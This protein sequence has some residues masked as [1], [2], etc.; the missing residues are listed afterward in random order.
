VIDFE[1]IKKT[2]VNI[3]K[4]NMNIQNGESVLVLNDVPNPEE[5]N[6]SYSKV[7]D[8]VERSLMARKIYDLLK[9]EFKEH[10]IEYIVYRSVGQHGTEPPNEIAEKLIDYDV[11]L[12]ITTFSITHTKAKENATQKGTRIASMP[13]LKVDMLAAD[14]AI[15]ADYNA[16][17]G[18]TIKIAEKLTE[19]KIARIITEYGTDIS[20]SI[21][22]RNGGKDTGIIAK[23]GEWGNLP[24]GEAYIAPVEGTANG[25]IVVPAGW[26]YALKED[27]ELEFRDGYV[28]SIKG[29]GKVGEAFIKLLSFDDEKVKHRRN[30]AELGIGTNPRAKKPDNVLEAEKIKGT[31]HIAIGDSSHLRG[32][33][34]SDLHEDFVLFEP[35]LYLDGKV[36][37]KKGKIL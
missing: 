27:M 25:R 34:E 15:A 35:T 7:N 33:T 21:E 6:L 24:G 13:G 32:I 37:I 11:V 30:C 10:K 3:L 31:V 20:F 5:W 29:G 4:V 2:V 22:N 9:E 17:H 14:G 16:I 26:Y 36:I 1:D 28:I 19:A 8:F 18:E 12:A 23:K